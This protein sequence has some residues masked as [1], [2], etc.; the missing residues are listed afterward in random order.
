MF[1]S[2][3][4]G[5]V[6]EPSLTIA[7][8]TSASMYPALNFIRDGLGEWLKA[9]SGAPFSPPRLNFVAF[10]ALARRWQSKVVELTFERL[11][12]SLT[13]LAGLHC[14]ATSNL[15]DGLSTALAD[16]SSQA[17]YLL[18]DGCPSDSGSREMLRRLST[19]NYSLQ[20][21]HVVLVSSDLGDNT[22]VIR[23]LGSSQQW[24]SATESGH[25]STQRALDFY[26][27][28][29]RRSLGSVRYVRLPDPRERRTAYPAE[30]LVD[31]KQ[32]VCHRSQVA[33]FGRPPTR[34]PSPQRRVDTPSQRSPTSHI[35]DTGASPPMR[36]LPGSRLPTSFSSLQPTEGLLGRHVVAD[37][38]RGLRVFWQY[39][40]KMASTL[41]AMFKNR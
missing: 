6:N 18:T 22:A 32:S 5:P 17:L 30:V 10:D 23:K 19:W 29:A 8:D 21:I 26:T 35:H 3:L 20:P 15:A 14:T 4:L 33:P 13:W 25:G 28:L 34:S 12:S 2:S 1:Y 11:K 40:T 24:S 41:L 39:P 9:C 7:I 37:F 38:V 36:V 27:E 16:S 31:F